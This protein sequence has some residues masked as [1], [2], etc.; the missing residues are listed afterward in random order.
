MFF[1]TLL[2]FLELCLV[3]YIKYN[4]IVLFIPKLLL[5]GSLMLLGY[6]EW[7]SKKLTTFLFNLKFHDHFQLH[8]SV[9]YCFLSWRIISGTHNICENMVTFI[10][11]WYI[12]CWQRWNYEAYS[13]DNKL[14]LN[15]AS[16]IQSRMPIWS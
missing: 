3:S 5:G 7:L 11:E 4:E 10:T 6:L 8:S 12:I 1:S 2:F 15:C 9:L 14:H 16:F 13:F